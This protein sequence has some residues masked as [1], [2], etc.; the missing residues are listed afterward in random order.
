MLKCT[1]GLFSETKLTINSRVIW[2]REKSIS[3]QPT[4]KCLGGRLRGL[5][6]GQ[7]G[8]RKWDG[9]FTCQL[10]CTD[11]SS[12]QLAYY[13]LPLA[14][15]SAVRTRG[16]RRGRNKTGVKSTIDHPGQDRESHLSSDADRWLVCITRSQLSRD[17]A[18]IHASSQKDA[19]K[20]KQIDSAV[21]F[22][23]VEKVTMH[24]YDVFHCFQAGGRG[25]HLKVIEPFRGM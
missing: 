7:S 2:F 21:F 9:V 6:V 10:V 11:K 18:C 17:A 23:H 19:Q 15:A 13:S 14:M 5:A 16:L 8:G 20:Q 4:V 12:H 25:M 3:A 22:L 1:R 24:D